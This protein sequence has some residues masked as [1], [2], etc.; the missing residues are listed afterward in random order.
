MPRTGTDARSWEA[1]GPG[2]PPPDPICRR[3]NSPVDTARPSWIV[4]GDLGPL[5]VAEVRLS[6]PDTIIVLDASRWRCA[7]RALRR[8]HERLDFWRWLWTW[9][10]KSFPALKVSIPQSA[11]D[12][13]L[14]ILRTPAELDRLLV[15]LQGKP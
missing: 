9:R 12:A 14:L 1:E 4:D 10:R 7:W 13:D 15:S 8:S 5:D 2:G 11:P 6:A 3:N